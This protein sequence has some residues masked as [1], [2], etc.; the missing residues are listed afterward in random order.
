MALKLRYGGG[1][2]GSHSQL[3]TVVMLGYDVS[4]CVLDCDVVVS[5]KSLAGQS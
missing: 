2:K 3:S 1:G 4:N 5:M